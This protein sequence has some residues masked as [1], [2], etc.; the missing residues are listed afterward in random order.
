MK[1]L[2]GVTGGISAYKAADIIGALKNNGCEI[3]VIMT[4]K[5]KEY[6][7]PL[8]LATLSKNPI[9][10][11]TQEWA[12]HGRIDHVDLAEWADIYVVVPATANTIAKIAQGIADNMLTS[13]YLDFNWK[14][15]GSKAF[16]LCPAMNT[17]MYENTQTV[18]NISMIQER[19]NHRVIEP[20]VGMLACGKWGVGKLPG[21]RFIC[22]VIMEILTCLKN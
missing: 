5:A 19:V 9:Y 14:K 2:L 20:D 11:D 13:T 7:T 15:G 18:N 12:P 6:I 16:L 1:V 3:K 22:A 4:N 17:N 21:T 8:T 10:D